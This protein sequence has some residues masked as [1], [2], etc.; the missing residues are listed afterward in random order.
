MVEPHLGKGIGKA[1]EIFRKKGLLA[2]QKYYGRYKD[3][4]FENRAEKK[5]SKA[6]VGKE[7]KPKSNNFNIN[8]EYRD[9]KG[10][11]MKQKE[12]Y[13]YLCYIFHNKL[14]GMKKLEKKQKREELEQK[15][16]NRDISTEA[17]TFKYLKNQQMKTNSPFVMLQG[18]NNNI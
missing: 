14:P 15:M 3:A 1:L 13:R 11:L 2:K 4:N 5:E 9:E 17:K 6:D 18:K 8:L 10:R 12:A 16:N 7:I